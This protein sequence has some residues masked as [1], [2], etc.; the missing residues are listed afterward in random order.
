MRVLAACVLNFALLA[1]SAAARD[2]FVSNVSGDDRFTG[3]HAEKLA[4]TGGPVRSI[5]KALR[6]AG[7]GDRIV[8]SNTEKPYCESVSLVGAR[9]SGF[10]QQPFVIEGNGAVLDG[11]APVPATGWKHYREAEFRFH[12]PRTG[13]QQLFLDG[14]PAVRVPVGHLAGSP[15]KLQPR[16][17]CLFESDIYFCVEK[18]KLPQDYNLAYASLPTGITLYHVQYV[19]IKDLTVQGFQLDGINAQNSAMQVYLSGVT[20]RGN[21]R[22]G[23]TIGGASQVD[24]ELCLLG[25]NGT[26]QLLTQPYSETHL[27]ESDLLGNTAPA[28]VDQGGR[29]YLGKKRIEGGRETIE[30]DEGEPKPDEGEPP[31]DGAQ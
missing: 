14:R 3:E 27:H 12:P 6:L 30:P 21:G 26:A 22:N 18:T 29:V 4:D 19:G 15:P 16:Q 7:S 17:W 1:A 2:I 31:A 25:N 23:V 9:H 8:L 10:P 24:L 11:S 20:C 5:A 13:F 28:W